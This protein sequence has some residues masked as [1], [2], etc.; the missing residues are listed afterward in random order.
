[1]LLHTIRKIKIATFLSVAIG[2]FYSCDDFVDEVP[3]SQ[4]SGLAFYQNN[5]DL[6]LALVAAYSQMSTAYSQY[7]INWGEF[8]SDNMEPFGGNVARNSMHNSS[9]DVGER[10]ILRWFDLYRFID[11][12]NRVI[13]EGATIEGVDNNILGQAYAMRAKVYFDIT[14]VWGAVPLFTESINTIDNAFKTRTPAA[15]IMANVVIPDMLRAEQLISTPSSNF[16]FSQS[17]VLALQ[18]EVYLWE[19]ENQLAKDAIEKLIALGTHSLV[20]SPEDWQDLFI[21]QV[22]NFRV[23]DGPGK[24]QEGPELIFSLNY[25]LGQGIPTSGLARAY[26]AGAKITTITR[27]VE[28]KWRNRFPL[29]T[30]WDDLYPDTAPVFTETIIASDGSDSIVPLYGDWRLFATREGGSFEDGVG[31]VDEGEARVHKWQKNAL[32]LVP[33]ND[34]TDIVIYRYADMILMLAEAELKLNNAPRAL[35]LINQVR[36]ARQLP[37]ATTEQFGADFD[38]QIDFLLDERQFELLGEGKRWWDLVRNDKA[39]EVMNPILQDRGENPLTEQRI[40]WP[41]WDQH[42]IEN[43]NLTQTL[44]W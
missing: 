13:N 2:I 23:P 5:E 26:T 41:V 28:E 27:E 3:E 17:S 9:M 4:I 20:R 34:D 11:L 40:L 33:S 16:V 30:I 24:V 8:R 36:T 21:N 43:P 18:A 37:L 44:G 29:D 22:A 6:Q 38:T 10:N 39:L 35:E 19:R 32:G 31:T 15:E 7:H 25:F 14:R 12:T 1:M 42:L